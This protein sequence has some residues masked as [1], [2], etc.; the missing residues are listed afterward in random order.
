MMN[1]LK[2]MITETL[3]VFE[4][5]FKPAS[6]EEIKKRR[7][8]ASHIAVIYRGDRSGESYDD[9]T[10]DKQYDA[11]EVRDDPGMGLGTALLLKN[12][13]GREVIM[14]SIDFDFEYQT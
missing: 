10:Y 14:P 6:P 8:S 1:D 9:F 13:K 7:D 12:D 11:I 3:K 5:I 4:D 2:G